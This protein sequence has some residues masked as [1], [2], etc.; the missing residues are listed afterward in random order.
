MSEIK[1][2]A[3]LPEDWTG[4]RRI[5]LEGIASGNSTF[6]TEAPSWEQWDANHLQ[7]CRLVAVK[8]NSV[9][10]WAV[11][12][13]ISA[14]P[15]YR[16]VAEVSVYVASSVHGQGVG[17][18]LMRELVSAS[19]RQGFWTLQAG[20]FPENAASLALHARVGFRQVGRRE[21]MGQLHGAWRDVV[22]VERRV[23][24]ELH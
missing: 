13:A 18:A 2:R 10:G 23:D 1:L 11:L 9:V 19:E 15:I 24:S 7:T 17:S 20:I 12:A 5:Y 8:D 4:V 6:Q 22:L 3:M 21:K 14:R 16:G